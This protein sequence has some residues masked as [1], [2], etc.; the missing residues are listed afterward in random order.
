MLTYNLI[1]IILSKTEKRVLVIF[2]LLFLLIVLFIGLLAKLY[3]KTSIK[4]SKKIDQYVIDY[5]KYGFV[6]NP[7][8]FK[9]V[10]NQKNQLLL[11]KQAWFPLLILSS[12]LI[13]FFT[14]YSVNNFDYNYIWKLYYD[15]L[16]KFEWTWAQGFIPYPT[17]WPHINYETSLIFYNDGKSIVGYIFLVLFIIGLVGFIIATCKF[18]SREKRIKEKAKTIFN[19]SLDN[20]DSLQTNVVPQNN[21]NN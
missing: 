20:F 4:D 7:S 6:K 14:Y 18:N 2:C 11:L 10:A 8:E 15:M 3:K 21:I 5:I 12:S 1:Q 19:S 17:E 13:L 16:I 9:Q